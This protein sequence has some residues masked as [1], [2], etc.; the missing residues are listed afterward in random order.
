MLKVGNDSKSA[1]PLS[2]E[3][4]NVFWSLSIAFSRSL[5]EPLFVEIEN[6]LPVIPSS[7]TVE[8]RYVKLFLPIDF[9]N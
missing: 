8:V 5:S 1:S 2:A 9:I 4:M 7:K 3:W 6:V